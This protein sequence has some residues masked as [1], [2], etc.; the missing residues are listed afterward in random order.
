MGESIQTV[1]KR[2]PNQFQ[3]VQHE[4][5]TIIQDQIKSSSLVNDSSRGSYGFSLDDFMGYKNPSWHTSIY[6]DTYPKGVCD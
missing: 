6:N 2:I 4:A 5:L 1:R 3:I